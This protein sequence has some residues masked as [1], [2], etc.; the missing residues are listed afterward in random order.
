MEEKA[1][2]QENIGKNLGR[3]HDLKQEHRKLSEIIS[4]DHVNLID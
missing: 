3:S 4:T 2:I 1:A